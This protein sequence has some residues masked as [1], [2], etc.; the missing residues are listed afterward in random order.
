MTASMHLHRPTVTEMSL[1]EWNEAVQRA[2]KR[3]HLTYEQLSEMAVRR[4]FSS[5]EAKKLWLAIGE[6][7][8]GRPVS[9]D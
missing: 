1:T 9:A 4:N 6:Q 7:G 3:L 8:E 2:L 5:L